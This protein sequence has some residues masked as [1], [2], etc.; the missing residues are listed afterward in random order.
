MNLM[1]K[2]YLVS[3]AGLLLFWLLFMLFF[4]NSRYRHIRTFYKYSLKL[5]LL[6][7]FFYLAILTTSL[8][9]FFRDTY[10]FLPADQWGIRW[11]LVW[12]IIVVNYAVTFAAVFVRPVRVTQGNVAAMHVKFPPNQLIFFP[13]AVCSTCMLAK[14]ARSKHCSLC[15]GCFAFYDHHC[16]W[17]NN[18]VGLGN[19]KWFAG[20]LVSNI[21]I[22]CYGMALTGKV[23]LQQFPG[24][25]FPELSRNAVF[26]FVQKSWL[27]MKSTPQNKNNGTLLLLCVLFAM[28]LFAFTGEHLRM[29]YVGATTNEQD[30]WGYIQYLIQLECLYRLETGTYLGER[31]FERIGPHDLG[32][33]SLRSNEQV[34]G[35]HVSR[36]V[37]I[38]NITEVNNIY[39]DGFCRNFMKRME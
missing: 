18:C 5:S 31:Y 28:V 12:T 15:G 9:I 11:F 25:D 23:I 19:Y 14:P 24:L 21:L 36:L 1:V 10:P 29:V 34:P 6:I 22:M 30:K 4:G 13:D 16:I 20:F 7:P 32:L 26:R 35:L 8:T 17:L 33:L 39:D 37:K 3:G 2:V 27:V 38:D